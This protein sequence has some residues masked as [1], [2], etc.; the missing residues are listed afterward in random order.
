MRTER[1]TLT[2]AAGIVGKAKSNLLKTLKQH[3]LRP[4]K[5]MRY[6]MQKVLLAVKDGLVRDKN[7]LANI[8]ADPG[9]LIE[10]RLIEQVRKLTAEADTFEFK[11]AEMRGDYVTRAKWKADVGRIAEAFRA[12]VNIWI[13]STAAEVGDAVTKGRLEHGRALA[14]QHIQGAFDAGKEDNPDT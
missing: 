4:D 7:A 8:D 12:A 5:N 2:E 9:S 11:L 3:G 6:D 13:Q 1:R 14:F 10:K